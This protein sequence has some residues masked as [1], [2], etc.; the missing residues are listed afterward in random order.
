MKTNKKA[1]YV[2]T[3]DV[4]IEIHSSRKAEVQILLSKYIYDE[5]PESCVW[6]SDVFINGECIGGSASSES[7][8]AY[9]LAQ[10]II[11]E[12]E[13]PTLW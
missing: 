13:H 6:E 2:S 10:E 3:D 9:A 7:S 8:S 11:F 5:D 1:T 12:N 4:G